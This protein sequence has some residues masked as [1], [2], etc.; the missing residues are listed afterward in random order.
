M[1]PM[2]PYKSIRVQKLRIPTPHGGIP[3]LLLSP[4]DAPSN[5]TGVLWLHGGGY[6][7]GMK[8]MVYAS[9]AA[10]LVRDFGAVVLSP[11]YRL[12]LQA[13]YRTPLSEAAHRLVRCS[14]RSAHG[15]R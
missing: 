10:D 7:V 1:R 4:V 12:A 15:R 14:E 9:R 6:A 2:R 8:E 3:A 11:G 13:P 5:A